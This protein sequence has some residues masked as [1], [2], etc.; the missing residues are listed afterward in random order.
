MGRFIIAML[1]CLFTATSSAHKLAPSLL[2]IDQQESG[3]YHVIW[4]TPLKQTGGK[5]EPDLPLSLIHI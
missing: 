4:K 3:L 5:V 1:S 2:Q